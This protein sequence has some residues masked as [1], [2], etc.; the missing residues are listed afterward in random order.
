MHYNSFVATMTIALVALASLAALIWQAVH[1]HK[2]DPQLAGILG[3]SLGAFLR[4]PGAA[5]QV[6]IQQPPGQPVPVDTH[7]ED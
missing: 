7:P 1:G 6:Q 2:T 4:V 3:L 5:D